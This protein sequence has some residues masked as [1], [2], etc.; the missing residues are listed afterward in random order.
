[1][2][3]RSRR[4]LPKPGSDWVTL[5]DDGRHRVAIKEDDL[6][7]NGISKDRIPKSVMVFLDTH[8]SGS[9]EEVRRLLHRVLAAFAF[10][11]ACWDVMCDADEVFSNC[12]PADFVDGFFPFLMSAPD[13]VTQVKWIKYLTC[14][15]MAK[16]LRQEEMPEVPVGLD[17]AIGSSLHFPLKGRA[18][19]HFKNLLHSRSSE[20]RP[21]QVMWAIL[22]GAKRGT[23]E[24]TEDFIM[25]TMLKHKAS[26]SQTLPLLTAEDTEAVRRK[27]RDIWRTRAA[28]GKYHVW[29]PNKTMSRAQS[30]SGNPNYHACFEMPRSGFGRAGIVRDAVRRVLATQWEMGPVFPTLWRMRET[31]PG[32][33]VTEYVSH[34]FLPEI[35]PRIATRWALENL[36][37]EAYCRQEDPT[38]FAE[39]CAILEPL[40]C[41]LITKGSALPYWACQP[42]QAAM[43]ERMQDCP[44]FKLTGCPLDGSMLEGL[45]QQERTLGLSFDKW[46]SGDY[47]AATDGLSQHVN[48][49]CLEEALLGANADPAMREVCR[50]VL[51]NHV[52]RY[53]KE[54]VLMAKKAGADLG[55]FKQSNGQLMG[56]P[57]SFP[58]LCAINLAAYWCALE[59]YTGRTFE[60][61]A[62]PVLVNGD[63]I[64]FR[65]NDEFYSIWKKWVAKVGFT[66]SPGK[67]YIS[68]DF[69]TVNS[70]GWHFR[71]T[72]RGH[73]LT[74]IG[75]LN[76]GLLYSTSSAKGTW[77]DWSDKKAARVACRPE[78]VQMPFVPKFNRVIEEACNPVR[79]LQRGKRYFRDLIRWHTHDG[80]INMHA[81]PEL[82]GLGVV[83]PPGATT[84]FTPWQQRVAGYLMSKWH[85][86]DI[87]H[88]VDCGPPDEGESGERIVDLNRPLGVSGR[89][90]YVAQQAPHLTYRPPVRPGRVVVREKLEP[91]R[92]GE[93]RIE[94]DS[95]SALNYQAEPNGRAARWGI[96]TL[97]AVDVRGAREFEG[98]RV[99]TPTTWTRE[100]RTLPCRR[101]DALVRSDSSFVMSWTDRWGATHTFKTKP[102]MLS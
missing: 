49:L 52:I 20:K 87:G 84:R 5:R 9:A 86:L 11:R 101:V 3:K 13:E 42:M 6:V 18:R 35:G 58:I 44:A 70:E 95:V 79:A 66:L 51:G 99:M 98:S 75:F 73:T 32:V 50:Y 83:L 2:V 59:E 38:C 21:Q 33:V 14:W 30:R 89:V 16:F 7:D 91:L 15:P 100:I 65:A 72:V 17:E 85:S 102:V 94:K 69:V 1:M 96:K 36:H 43:W 41:R 12:P 26:L 62:L 55:Q 81:A 97:S 46:V 39:V 29:V 4:S 40:K 8:E 24:V 22:Q 61:N 92:E 34:D 31:R 78:N 53:P 93:T 76:T 23:L 60:A 80:E 19:K 82:G 57:L 56:C 67:N 45:L 48:R 64:C 25:A 77:Q 47:S 37:A 54:F 27:F 63:D 88:E 90:T 28:R 10:I 74:K 71:R 68:P